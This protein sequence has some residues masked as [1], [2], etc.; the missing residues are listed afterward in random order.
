MDSVT[1]Y[2]DE[3]G[4]AYQLVVRSSPSG[5]CHYFFRDIDGPVNLSPKELAGLELVARN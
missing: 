3:N 5:I 4:Q 1:D 2:Q